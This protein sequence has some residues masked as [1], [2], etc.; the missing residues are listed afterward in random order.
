[1]M[2]VGRLLEFRG[3]QKPRELIEMEHRMVAA[4]LAEKRNVLAEVHI[5]EMIGDKAAVTPLHAP[6]EF[7]YNLTRIFH[8]KRCDFSITGPQPLA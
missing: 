3:V 4:M 6:A 8:R 7:F 5:L 2:L 1:M